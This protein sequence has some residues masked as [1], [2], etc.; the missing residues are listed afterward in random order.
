MKLINKSPWTFIILIGVVSLFS[1]MTHE[2]ARSIS[3]PFLAMLG[4]SATMVGFIAGFGEFMGYAIRLVSGIIA[5]KTKQYWAVTFAG[6]ILNLLAIPALALAGSWQMA[7]VLII[8]ERTGRAIRNPSRDVMLSHATSS[9]GH[10]KGFGVHE[11]LDQTGAVLGPLIVGAVYFFSG[12]YS[13]SFGILLIPALLALSVLVVARLNYPRTDHLEVENNLKKP[14][15]SR[16]FYW[17]YLVAVSLIA[18]GFADYPLIAFH[19]NTTGQVSTHWIPVMY[20]I[21]MGVDALAALLLG[22]LF[23]KHGMKVLVGSTLLSLLF[24]PLVFMGNFYTA[25]AGMV[26]WGVGMAAQESVVRAVLSSILPPE[27]K[28]TGFGLFNATFGLFWF[29]GSFFMGWL[30]DISITWLII[31][32]M[33]IQLA[34]IPLFIRLSHKR[35]S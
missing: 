9:I 19:F 32:S 3:G 31:F 12:N 2:G 7:A 18:V 34:S 5:D 23:D 16:K 20:A 25:V 8:L 11:A 1:D 29:L 35:I 10:G 27:K 6:Y 28:A 15:T 30:Y 13:R 24:A 17:L 33:G 21:A 4:A 14:V 22:R 26:C